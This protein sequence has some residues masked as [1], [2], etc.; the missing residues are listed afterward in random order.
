MTTS[1]RE[2]AFNLIAWAIDEVALGN[3][4]TPER[5]DP[6]FRRLADAALVRF[7]HRVTG[8]T[9]DSVV[10]TRSDIRSDQSV[11]KRQATLDAERK[12]NGGPTS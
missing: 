6:E 3:G 12:F 2:I 8:P 11:A 5:I 4:Q 1:N 7:K 9:A 10:V